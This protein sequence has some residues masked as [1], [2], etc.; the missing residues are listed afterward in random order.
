MF[1]YTDAK[2]LKKEVKNA[3]T[4]NDTTAKEICNRLGISPQAYQKL[5]LKKNIC[6][7]D[8]KKVC[9]AMDCN[10]MIGIVRKDKTDD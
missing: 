6:F 4:N 5:F 7:T 10:L 2:Q 9:E 3:I 8:V 1:V